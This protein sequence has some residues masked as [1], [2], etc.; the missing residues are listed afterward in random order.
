MSIIQKIKSQQDKSKEAHK[1]FI[2]GEYGLT[3]TFWLYWFLPV[4][5]ITIADSIFP[6]SKNGLITNVMII[7]WSGITLFAIHNVKVTDKTLWKNISLGFVAFITITR[8]FILIS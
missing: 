8:I 6:T 4:A 7:F 5:F 1:K 2:Q 3:K